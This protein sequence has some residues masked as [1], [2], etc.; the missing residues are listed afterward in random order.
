VNRYSK[1]AAMPL[2]GG[3]LFIQS[4]AS[5]QFCSG[6]GEFRIGENSGFDLSHAGLFYNCLA[7]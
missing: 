4:F 7:Q 1:E 2:R 3:F 6:R 5:N